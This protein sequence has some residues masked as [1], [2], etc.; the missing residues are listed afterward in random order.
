ME[1]LTDLHESIEIGVHPLNEQVLKKTFCQ[2]R[3]GRSVIFHPKL[4][5]YFA[6]IPEA[7]HLVGVERGSRTSFLCYLC[8]TRKMTFLSIVM[9]L[10]GFFAKKGFAEVFYPSSSGG[11]AKS[12]LQMLSM[13]SMLPVLQSFLMIGIHPSVDI[14]AI[15]EFGP[16]HMLH[17]EISRLF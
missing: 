6:D 5:V 12:K 16:M 9:L 1:T 11:V 8:H 10:P 4:T 14:F 7:K 2:I 3:T 15:F 17:F 13:L